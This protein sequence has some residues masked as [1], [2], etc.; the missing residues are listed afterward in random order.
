MGVFKDLTGVKF[1]R[2]TVVSQ[3]PHYVSPSGRLYVMWNCECECGKFIVVRTSALT[4]KS[5]FS[6]SC[7]CF[8]SDATRE[9]ASTHKMSKT[10]EYT[11]YKAMKKRCANKNDPAYGNYGARGIKVCDRWLD[12]FDN[13]YAD[14]GERPQNTSLDRIDN[15]KGYSPENCKWSTRAEQQMNRRKFGQTSVYRGVSYCNTYNK[16]FAQVYIRGM[17]R[18]KKIGAYTK[19]YDAAVAYDKYVVENNLPNITNGLHKPENREKQG[20]KKF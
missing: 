19:E 8:S 14:M 17:G 20:G 2:L 5:S 11:S 12:S 15:D 18:S 10:R 4:S 9:R 7:G 13:F 1:Y 3:A 16:F 6:K